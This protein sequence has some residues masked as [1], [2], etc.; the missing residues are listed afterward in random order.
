MQYLLLTVLRSTI[1]ELA[2]VVMITTKLPSLGI[3]SDSL[4]RAC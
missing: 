3:N 4:V 2:M 1:E